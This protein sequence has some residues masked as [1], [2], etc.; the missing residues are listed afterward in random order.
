MAEPASITSAIFTNALARWGNDDLLLRAEMR[1]EVDHAYPGLLRVLD[2][3]ELRALFSSHDVLANAG[4]KHSWRAGV[5]AVIA[6][7]TGVAILAL[8]PVLNHVFGLSEKALSGLG[9]ALLALGSV[10]GIYQWIA[11]RKR[12]E[13]LGHRYWTERLRQMQF[14]F[15]LGNVALAVAAITDDA[16]LAELRQQRARRLAELTTRTDPQAAI[17]AIR[18]DLAE[19]EAW[20][21]RP[22][23]GLPPCDPAG[24]SSLLDALGLLRLRVQLDYVGRS[25]TPSLHGP[26]LRGKVLNALADLLTLAT[27]PI[28]AV[29][30]LAYFRGD[31]AAGQAWNSVLGTTGALG[32]VFRAI[33][34]GTRASAD[35]ERFNWYRASLLRLEHRFA[36]GDPR[37]KLAALRD[38]ELLSYQELRRFL[39]THSLARFLT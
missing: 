9:L 11:M 25:L 19:A 16:A 21:V 6:S 33:E 7:G 30:A 28:A 24:L 38:L 14:Q 32:L 10:L 23:T 36:E 34:Q 22:T 37:E 5:L 13:W 12:H 27:L 1:T 29:A 39:T 18:E 31:G 4:K 35:A 15:L 26:V 3:P 2:W 20:L 17:R 8:V